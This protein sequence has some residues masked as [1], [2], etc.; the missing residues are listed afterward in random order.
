MDELAQL[1]QWLDKVDDA[2][3]RLYEKWMK[4]CEQVG[5][6]KIRIGK[7]VFDRQKEQLVKVG[8]LGRLP[9]IEI[10]QLDRGSIRIVFQGAEGAY[11]QAAMRS[12]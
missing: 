12:G 4:L 11:G 3:V 7:K 10:P 9:F 6:Y 1:R 5:E 2:L 8:A